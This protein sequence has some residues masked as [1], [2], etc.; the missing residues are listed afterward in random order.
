MI[1]AG[2]C[3]AGAAWLVKPAMDEIFINKDEKALIIIPLI[4]IGITFGKAGGRLV[5]NYLMQYC[6]L[7][8][9]E[10]LREELFNKIIYLPM[11]FYEKTQV[12][13]LMS[14]VIN[15]VTAIRT[16]LPA[17]VMII[18]Q[19]ITMICLIGVAFYQNTTLAFW[20]IVVLPI[21][22]YPFIYFGRRLR[23]LGR[24]NQAKLADI[25]TLLQE[26]LSG[27]RVVKAFCT[28]KKEI[29]RFDKDNKSLIK[30]ILKQCLAG[31][32]S[33]QVMEMIGA[34]GIA[35]VL[36]FGGLQVISGKSDPGAFF[37]FV[38][39]LVMLYDPIK[40]L[41]SAN[42]DIQKALAGAERVFEI[43]DDPNLQV[44]HDGTVKFHE[45]FKE[46]SFENLTFS[47]N[48]QSKALDNINF[49]LKAGERVA[50][51][52]P[53]GAG[54]TTFVNLIP[55]FY[56][57]QKGQI[58]LNG[59][60]IRD[61]TLNSLRGNIAVVSQDNFLFNLSVEDNIKYGTEQVEE[62]EIIEASKAAFAHDFISDMPEG[63]DSLVG[64]RG[65]TLSGGQKQRITIARALVKNAP[66]L[67]LD[68][69]TSALDSEAESIVQMALDNLMEG[70]TSIVIA[71]R[72]STVIGA[73][74]IL[75]MDKGRIV[76]QGKHEELLEKSALYQKLYNMQYKTEENME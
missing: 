16:S 49:T 43:L 69:A 37:S 9:L 13:M 35:L 58:K 7:K 60:D 12:G 73:D 11:H 44:E 42:N 30:I 27:V 63:Y 59:R 5:Q 47:Y 36:W 56:E 28:E 64:E 72:L 22:F 61:Y 52:G 39:A 45:D 3:T 65:V 46:L 66:L 48:D 2:V 51:V 14:R 20:A 18:R 23:R 62:S 55:R 70:R 76:D 21:A 25:S 75:V 32:F 71:H 68:E 26:I 17:L 31:E 24:S 34:L 4:F 29:E 41:T 19:V 15:D 40:K 1:V 74:K 54:K 53:S 67:I 57:P 33:S 50:I 38:A 8:V 6:G 10:T